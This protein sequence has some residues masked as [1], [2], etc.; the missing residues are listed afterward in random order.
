MNIWVKLLCKNTWPT[1]RLA[2]RFINIKY[3]TNFK[4]WKNIHYS[5]VSNWPNKGQVFTSIFLLAV[6][7]FFF[8]FW[9]LSYPRFW[10]VVTFFMS[11]L[12]CKITRWNSVEFRREVDINR[13][14]S[15]WSHVPELYSPL[16]VSL[17]VG[18]SIC[19]TSITSPSFSNAPVFSYRKKDTWGP[20]RICSPLAHEPSE[21]SQGE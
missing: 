3:V 11:P 5:L 15:S 10:V 6:S 2:K 8:F 13:R 9:L 1:K 16:E 7:S 12:D 14:T 4:K 19:L 21:V 17:G 20:C 18:M